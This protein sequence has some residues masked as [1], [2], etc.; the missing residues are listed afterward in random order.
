MKFGFQAFAA[1]HILGCASVPRLRVNGKGKIIIPAKDSGDLTVYDWN[2]RK[3]VSVTLP[4]QFTHSALQN[5][6]FKDDLLVFE[7]FG[8][9]TI[10]V[11]LQTLE[12]RHQTELEGSRHFYGHGAVSP[13]GNWLVCTEAGYSG[14]VN[15]TASISIR[16]ARTLEKVGEMPSFGAKPH[17]II[18]FDEGIVAVS[19]QGAEEVKSNVSFISLKDKTLLKKVEIP[20]H[21]GFLAHLLKVSSDE[22]FVSATHHE[23]P[24]DLRT[25]EVKATIEKGGMEGS[26]LLAKIRNSLK[27]T[28]A[29]M[30]L[31]SR[32]GRVEETWDSEH[33][34]NFRNNFSVCFLSHKTG[35]IAVA[36]AASQRVTLWKNNK[37]LHTI[38]LPEMKPQAVAP[39]PDGSEF[40]VADS[41]GRFR[42]FST[43]DFRELRDQSFQL[44]KGPVHVEPLS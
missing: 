11:D 22:I 37:L 23:V 24:A 27:F 14:D 1:M 9:K 32:Q 13:D 7:Q 16:N 15:G 4:V 5:P 3:T 29:P 40:M 34:E 42:F 20:L 41:A 19:N 21:K 2:T 12:V 44:A 36:H 28:P 25:P 17:D 6:V 33:P 43:S 8:R 30:F 10:L 39:S 26:A 18:F 31:I 35:L 38:H